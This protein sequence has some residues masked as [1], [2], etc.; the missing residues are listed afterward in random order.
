MLVFLDLGGNLMTALPKAWQIQNRYGD[1]EC[2]P[3]KGCELVG[4]PS[5]PVR[6]LEGASD[7]TPAS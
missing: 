5:S 2:L 1:G 6:A 3:K 4:S 7:L